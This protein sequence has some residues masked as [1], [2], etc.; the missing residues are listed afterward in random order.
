MVYI[1]FDLCPRLKSLRERRLHIPP[2]MRVPDEI[3]SIVEQDVSR[4]QL[5]TGWDDLIRVAASIEGGWTSAVLALERFGSAA[6]A[7]P[8]HKAGTALGKL[9]RTMF[10]CDYVSNPIFRRAVL[11]ILHHGEAVHTL[12]RVIHFG[13][14]SA[15]HGRARI[16]S[17]LLRHIAPNHSQGINLRGELNFPI[18]RYSQRLIP[19]RFDRKEKA[20]TS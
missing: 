15:A 9:L 8:I 2:S 20:S 7:D 19:D 13:G 5:N 17:E 12:Q 4:R 1:G 14:I 10:L 6:R 18:A 11:R 3:E 16:E